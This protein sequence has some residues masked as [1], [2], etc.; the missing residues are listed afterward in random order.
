VAH[1]SAGVVKVP[2]LR[3]GP[4]RPVMSNEGVAMP[5][6]CSP[7]RCSPPQGSSIQLIN[8]TS[9]MRVAG[10]EKVTSPLFPDG[11]NSCSYEENLPL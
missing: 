9:Q 10:N 1:S 6:Q 7:R 8:P 2:D 5:K 4:G 3:E 11:E